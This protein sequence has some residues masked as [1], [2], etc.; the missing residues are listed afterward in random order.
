ML[1]AC[2]G[3]ATNM[4]RWHWQASDGRGAEERDDGDMAQ[5]LPENLGFAGH[6]TQG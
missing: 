1:D 6:T 5:P 4:Y 2:I 3:L